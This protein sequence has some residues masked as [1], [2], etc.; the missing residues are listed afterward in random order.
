MKHLLAIL[1]LASTAFGQSVKLPDKVLIPKPGLVYI[2]AE[3]F[4]AD[5]I[6]WWT[7]TDGIQVFPPDLV[8]V[9]L[10]TFF[11]F[12]LQEGVYKVSCIPAK[13][14]G[15]KAVIG[16]ISTVE[17]TVGAPVPPIP[18]TVTVPTVLMQTGTQAVASLKAVGL[19]GVIVGNAADVVS[20][21]AP[22]AGTV[23][24]GGSTVTV[25]TTPPKPPEPPS[26]IPADGFRVLIV[27]ETGDAG[28]IPYEQQ[29]IIYDQGV[30]DYLDSH[31]VKGADGKTP[32]RR[33]WDKDVKG[34]EAE[35][36]LWQ[37][38][39]KR[40]RASVPWILISTGKTGFEGPLPADAEDTLTLL[41]KYGGA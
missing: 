17:V 12:C 10:G 31:C 24:P 7:H 8:P 11:G 21:Q 14:I 16:Q 29:L 19:V 40:P 37:D 2:K 27:Y 41:K 36:K 34:I 15:G 39:F 28:K 30:R 33:I 38:A 25:T 5:D 23:V 1:L 9:K 3:T 20:A 18:V 6:R 35:S 4:D 13:A 26:P 22:V 32:E